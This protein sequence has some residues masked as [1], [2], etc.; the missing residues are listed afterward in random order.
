MRIL[1]LSIGAVAA[2]VLLNFLTWALIGRTSALGLAASD[3]D[4]WGALDGNDTLIVYAHYRG[5]SEA[6]SWT[7]PG[8]VS[9]AGRERIADAFTSS[10]AGADVRYLLRP[11]DALP[12]SLP[13][14]HFILAPVVRRSIPFFAHSSA[15]AYAPG[16]IA[17]RDQRWVW[18]FGWRAFGPP[19][20]SVS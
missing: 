13:E 14:R 8:D 9:D 12:D 5:E 16:F 19:E 17:T 15:A 4:A 3:F 2:F 11:L 1:K 10:G 6:A 7:E 20:L 18:V